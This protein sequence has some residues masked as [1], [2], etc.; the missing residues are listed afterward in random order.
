MGAFSKL[1]KSKD[2]N[3]YIGIGLIV[4]LLIGVVIYMY[5]NRK[6]DAKHDL[7]EESEL[8]RAASD[9]TPPPAQQSS[10]APK[11]SFA[12]PPAKPSARPAIVVFHSSSCHHCTALLPI[13]NQLRE[14][15]GKEVD[16]MDF[17]AHK[18]PEILQQNGIEGVPEIRYYPKGFPSK[19]FVQYANMPG[20]N[21][22]LDSLIR[23][24]MSHGQTA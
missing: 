11:E 14:Q 10:S 20:A 5:F 1:L 4:I 6:N 12:A 8:I 22:Q 18:E 3:L 15:I 21:R 24:A 16:V 7:E 2:R 13:W 23:F 9:N 19:E 17:E